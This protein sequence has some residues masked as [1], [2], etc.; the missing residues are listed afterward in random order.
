MKHRIQHP[1]YRIQPG[2]VWV[3]PQRRGGAERGQ[4]PIA[5]KERMER[6]A[7]RAKRSLEPRWGGAERDD[8]SPGTGTEMGAA[9]KR[10]EGGDESGR[11]FPTFS[12]DFRAFPTFSHFIFIL[13]PSGARF[14]RRGAETQSQAELGTK[15]GKLRSGAKRGRESPRKFGVLRV[16]TRCFTKV[17]T[18]QG[19]KSAIVRIVTGGD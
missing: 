11:F 3:S 7:K 10:R 5:A 4:N 16:V 17:R 18:D 1:E 9:G 15:L 13:W 8:R 2:G 19:R 12:R 14:H 6:R